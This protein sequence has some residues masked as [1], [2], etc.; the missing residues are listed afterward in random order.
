VLQQLCVFIAANLTI[1]GSLANGPWQNNF[2]IT[3][4]DQFG[5]VFI[6]DVAVFVIPPSL[7]TTTQPVPTT[8]MFT[9]CE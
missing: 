5:N 9:L 3:V 6:E 1:I 4:T 7:A 8:G 2:T